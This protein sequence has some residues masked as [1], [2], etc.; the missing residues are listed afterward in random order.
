M[1]L[2]AYCECCPDAD[3]GE[4]IV[5]LLVLRPDTCDAC[6]PSGSAG[7]SIDWTPK[8]LDCAGLQPSPGVPG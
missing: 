8:S 3:I 6:D 7:L 2:G 5:P 1:G 4:S